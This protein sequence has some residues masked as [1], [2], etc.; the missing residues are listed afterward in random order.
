MDSTSY[1]KKNL[2]SRIKSSNDESFLRA[3]QTILDSS[4]KELYELSQN[5][6]ESIE[7]GRKDIKNGDFKSHEQVMEEMTAWLKNNNMIQASRFRT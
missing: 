5:Q 2:I 7:A 1:L 3:L 6:R 4:E